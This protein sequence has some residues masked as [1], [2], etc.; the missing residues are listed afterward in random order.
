MLARLRVH[1]I[2]EEPAFME[3]GVSQQHEGR[4]DGRCADARGLK[5]CCAFRGVALGWVHIIRDLLDSGRLVALDAPIRTNLPFPILER[6]SPP[7]SQD[8][9]ALRDWLARLGSPH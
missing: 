1:D 8:G 6:R 9:A 5:Q 2:R 3:M 7:I 4:K